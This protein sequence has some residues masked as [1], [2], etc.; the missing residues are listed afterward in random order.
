M[1]TPEGANPFDQ[2]DYTNKYRHRRG[3]EW[4]RARGQHMKIEPENIPEL[5]E[6]NNWTI[7]GWTGWKRPHGTPAND[8]VPVR[9]MGQWMAVKCE[10]PNWRHIEVNVC[11]LDIRCMSWRGYKGGDASEVASGGV[12]IT[13]ATSEVD[14]EQAKLHGLDLLKSLIDAKEGEIDEHS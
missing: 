5:I 13:E 7:W 12:W 11:N 1:S 14:R 4:S 3:G 2:P 9:L 8:G 10:P 6:H